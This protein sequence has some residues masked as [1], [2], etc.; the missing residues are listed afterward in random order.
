MF[1]RASKQKRCRH[2]RHLW[3]VKVK[4][5]LQS[6]LLHFMNKILFR[7]ISCNFLMMLLITTVLLSLSSNKLDNN[8]NRD[9][10]LLMPMPLLLIKKKSAI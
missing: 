2:F 6:F 8:F 10:H 9:T 3:L 4:T 1:L 7:D 5:T